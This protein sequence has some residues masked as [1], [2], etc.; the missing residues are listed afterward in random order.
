MHKTKTRTLATLATGPLLAREVRLRCP[1]CP[2]PPLFSQQLR[3]LAPPGQRFGYDLIAWVGLQ[4]YQHMRQR[5]EIA[6]EL[7]TRGIPVST[8]SL[9]AICDR[10]LQLLQ[11][12]HLHRAPALRAAMAHGYPLHLDAT[13]DQGRGG[14]FVCL[15]GWRDWVLH[16]V[17]IRSENAAELCPAIDQTLAAFGLPVATMRDLGSAIG[18]AVASCL[19][20]GTADLVCHFHLLAAI[21]RKLLD[22]EHA[23]LNRTLTQL[24]I[25]SGL[26]SLLRPLR[27][28]SRQPAADARQLDLPA[29]LLWTLQG[30]GRKHPPYPFALT[31]WNLY[32]RCLQ[33][34]EMAR[35][36]LPRP[37][38]QLEQSTL[39]QVRD[40]LQPLFWGSLGLS[41]TAARIQSRHELFGELRSVLRLSHNELRGRQPGPPPS[42]SDSVKL[43]ESLASRVTR[44]RKKLRQRVQQADKA[45]ADTSP[46]SIV[47]RYLDRYR[48]QL[49]G[50]PVAQD[51]CGR[52]VAVVERT[53][54]PSE[55]SFAKTKR[56][57]RR[58][59]GH[60]NLGRDMQD[61]PAQ[62]ALTANLLDPE[63]VKI[64]SGTLQDLPRAF[65]ELAASGVD[66]SAAALDRPRRDSHLR[67]RIR[68]WETDA[69]SPPDESLASPLETDPQ[70]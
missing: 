25:R 31:H 50:H 3:D 21:G 6:A 32:Q 20:P 16:A 12:L 8:G 42:P 48:D 29:L 54:N 9:S 26:R 23:A 7:A 69:K 19:P 70:S 24:G 1:R 17:R 28:Q 30:D 22:A 62:A 43:L 49:F 15:D 10:F 34:D 33:F 14:L 58:R 52:I 46:E 13:C 36:R 41:A 45:Q 39:E 5:R 55:H 64:L 57:L 37:R 63:Y 51:E 53:N 66:W 61:Q 60:A 44:F 35:K 67:R 18:K 4:R 56:S 27:D 38:S 65:A 40:L 2:G 59:V 11:A 47:L 68:A